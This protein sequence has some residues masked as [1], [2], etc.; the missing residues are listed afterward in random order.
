ML[1]VYYFQSLFVSVHA[2]GRFTPLGRDV[3]TG[4][5]TCPV[6]GDRLVAIIYCVLIDTFGVFFYL[7]SKGK[8][9]KHCPPKV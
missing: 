4:V 6:R 8:R 9:A 7:I 1:M 2:H 5:I 3:H